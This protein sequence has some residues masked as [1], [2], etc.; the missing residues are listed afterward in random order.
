M[1]AHRWVHHRLCNAKP[2]HPRADAI[3]QK[4]AKTLILASFGDVLYSCCITTDVG[5]L[6]HADEAINGS[7]A[8]CYAFTIDLNTMTVNR[9]ISA[10]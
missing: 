5:V 3:T 7:L 10:V 4:V 2:A 9:I 1:H 8:L 6:E